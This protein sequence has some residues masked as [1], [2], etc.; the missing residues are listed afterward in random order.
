M[1]SIAA[2]A[3]EEPFSIEDYTIDDLLRMSASEKKELLRKYKETYNPY[4]IMDNQENSELGITP[5]WTS[6]EIHSGEL[7]SIETH[8]MITLD[9]ISELINMGYFIT[10]DSSEMVLIAL[11]ISVASV[12][13]DR[14]LNGIGFFY[15]GHFYDPATKK[16]YLGVGS[17]ART[18]FVDEI[19]E[20]KKYFAKESEIDIESAN[21]Q[22]AI[23]HV[24]RAVH[25]LQ[26]A[27]KPH[28]ATNNIA[29]P[30]YAMPHSEFEEYVYENFSK[31]SYKA[32]WPSDSVDLVKDDMGMI[33]HFAAIGA[34]FYIGYVDNLN[35]RSGW[36]YAAEECLQAAI[37]ATWLALKL[38]FDSC[39]KT[40]VL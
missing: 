31:F 32:E 37:T 36:Q 4:G 7:T 22:K 16:N 38:I 6:G 3:Y 23:E 2:F 14:K 33:V 15:A 26:D 18:N 25:Y 1:F 17:T 30:L 35:D 10:N 27:C 20:A 21:F 13:P 11:M 28:H 8:E 29:S 24:G 12:L 34:N 5:Y 19:A 39:G 40:V 9:A